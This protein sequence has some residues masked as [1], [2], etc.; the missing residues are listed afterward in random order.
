M[1]G[2]ARRRR[3]RDGDGA[4]RDVQSD[5]TKSPNVSMVATVPT[6]STVAPFFTSTLWNSSPFPLCSMKGVLH[7]SRHTQHPQQLP[8]QQP[9]AP[10]RCT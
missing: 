8:P 4:D 6:F 1:R 3:G 2:R 5:G 9:L 7:V 10:D